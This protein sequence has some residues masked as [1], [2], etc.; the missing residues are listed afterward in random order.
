MGKLTAAILQTI[1]MSLRMTFF[2][3]AP[4]QRHGG[5]I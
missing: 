1:V 3:V 4:H 2:C 5:R